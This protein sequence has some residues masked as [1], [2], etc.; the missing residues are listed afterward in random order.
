MTCCA[1]CKITKN[2]SIEESICDCPRFINSEN[3]MII[4]WRG[5]PMRLNDYI[6]AQQS[7]NPIYLQQNKI[8]LETNGCVE[9]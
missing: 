5:I 7:A 9:K 2:E 8:T 3:G 6:K 4:V 1:I